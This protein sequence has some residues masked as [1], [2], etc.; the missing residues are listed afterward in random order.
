MKIR[1]AIA[2]ALF[3]TVALLSAASPKLLLSWKNPGFSGGSFHNV[4]VLGLNG[5]AV[6]RAEFEDQLTAALSRPGI[7]VSPSYEFLARPDATPI[8]MKDFR[9]LVAEQK[10]D[11]IVVSRIVKKET[12]TT[13]VPGT[14]YN[15][16]PYYSTFYGYYTTVS[17][18]IY[19]PGYMQTEKVAQVEINFYATTPPDGE[20]VWTCTT[21]TF[22]ARSAMKN[23]RD[24]V[25]LVSKE[26]EKQNIIVSGK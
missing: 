26:L 25:K 18:A 9:E 7:T 6:N 23:I 4:L 17:P 8:D 10:F 21:N 16:I 19:S 22:D 13:Y 15:P 20:L 24:V 3:L 2:V 1:S 14:V 5:K 11:G 12:K